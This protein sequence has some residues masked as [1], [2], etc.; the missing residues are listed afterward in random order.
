LTLCSEDFKSCFILSSI[1]MKQ[2]PSN[3]V[4]ADHLSVV[5]WGSQPCV[6]GILLLTCLHLVEVLYPL[7]MSPTWFYFAV[8]GFSSSCHSFSSR[9]RMVKFRHA[10]FLRA[11][12]SWW[13]WGF[14]FVLHLVSTLLVLFSSVVGFFGAGGVLHLF[15]F[16]LLETS[17]Q[18]MQVLGVHGAVLG[19]HVFLRA[20]SCGWARHYV[21]VVYN[22]CGSP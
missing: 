18:C 9:V 1:F 3:C 2:T 8:H 16:W 19:V 15:V 20:V 21:F 13:A 4:L 11:A 7:L 10:W 22:S 5:A 12:A 6:T 14:C 17:C